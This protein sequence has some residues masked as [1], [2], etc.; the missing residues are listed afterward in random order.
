MA[1]PIDFCGGEG[2]QG[3]SWQFY[4]LVVDGRRGSSRQFLMLVLGGESQGFHYRPR[5]WLWMRETGVLM[6]VPD[7]G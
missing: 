6:A 2:I 4:K 7:A 5:N 1:V 3:F